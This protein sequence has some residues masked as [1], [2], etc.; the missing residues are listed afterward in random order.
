[1]KGRIIILET[2]AIAD[3]VRSDDLKRLAVEDSKESRYLAETTIIPDAYLAMDSRQTQSKMNMLVTYYLYK[4]LRDENINLIL[5][6]PEA[7][8]IDRRIRNK[9]VI[10][11]LPVW[12][13]EQNAEKDS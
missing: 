10:I 9:A 3:V 2:G 5:L 12:E 1:M 7:K 4:Q 6:T 11:S 13:E 8:L